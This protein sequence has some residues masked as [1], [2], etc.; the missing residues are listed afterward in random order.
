MTAAQ[1]STAVLGKVS[2]LSQPLTA[3]LP[4]SAFC[5]DISQPGCKLS[6]LSSHPGFVHLYLEQKLAPNFSNENGRVMPEGIYTTRML[7]RDYSSPQSTIKLSMEVVGYTHAIHILKKRL[8]ED[9]LLTFCFN[10]SNANFDEI[11]LC[12]IPRLNH[13]VDVHFNRSKDLIN[14]AIKNFHIYSLDSSLLE[15]RTEENDIFFDSKNKRLIPLSKQQKKCMRY[16]LKGFTAKEIAAQLGL[17]IRTVRHYLEHIKK[18]SSLRNLNE[19]RIYVKSAAT[20]SKN[21]LTT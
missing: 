18:K 4:L 3:R 1:F 12:E 20:I 8:S 2:D 17:S 5:H 7:S 19:I 15:N 6:I 13:F 10:T 9:H 11:L 14:D 21:S 16:L